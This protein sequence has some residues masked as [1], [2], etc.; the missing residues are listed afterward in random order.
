MHA[1]AVTHVD[2]DD[3]VQVDVRA[4]LIGL[5]TGASLVV[6]AVVTSAAELQAMIITWGLY[7]ERG[8]IGPP[9][10]TGGRK[11]RTATQDVS[12]QSPDRIIH[13]FAAHGSG[14]QSI[15]QVCAA[16]ALA[17]HTKPAYCEQ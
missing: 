2:V 4:V 16:R 11:E 1:G 13:W 12:Q 3:T 14:R 5:A 7:G 8:G 6:R 10:G 17:N 9:M 15:R